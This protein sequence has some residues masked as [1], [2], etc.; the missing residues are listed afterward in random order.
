MTR[1]VHI[2][3]RRLSAVRRGFDHADGARLEHRDDLLLDAAVFRHISRLRTV[4]TRHVCRLRR[5][6]V[7]AVSIGHLGT[8][9]CGYVQLLHQLHMHRLPEYQRRLHQL[10]RGLCSGELD[11]HIMRAWIVRGG[12]CVKLFAMHRGNMVS[13][14]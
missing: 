12:R 7:Y 4:P 11:L 8:I 5:S 6:H 2:P 9:G 14:R 3:G 13:R 10:H 1:A